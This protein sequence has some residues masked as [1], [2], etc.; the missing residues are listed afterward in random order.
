MKILLNH[1]SNT[2]SLSDLVNKNG[3]KIK[4]NRLIRSDAL[5]KINT[6]DQLT[7]VK[8][9]QLKRVIDLRCDNE[10]SNNPDVVID[11]VEYIHNPVLPNARVGIT[12]KGN[13]E[14]DFNDFVE[15]IY[16][17]GAESSVQFMTKV[18]QELVTSDFSNQAYKRF[19]EILSTP[20]E[21]AT[22]W[23]CSAGKD[24]A[25][26][27][28][29]LILYVLDFSMDVI[30]EDYLN[31]NSFYQYKIEQ[32]VQRYGEAY[33]EVLTTIF[34]VNRAYIDALLKSIDEKYGSF[35]AYVTNALGIDAKKKEELQ[36][37]YL[38]EI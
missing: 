27:A 13:D 21:G 5:N 35:E 23:H 28:T 38:E 36:Q 26:F 31:T 12:K 30:I 33:R 25:G 7:L 2:R 32:S 19:L 24:R 20:V 1:T 15:A 10:A 18:Y 37:L 8:E 17:N 14:E 22:L 34:G 16:K 6:A 3:K 4:E 29:I 9:V 11:Q